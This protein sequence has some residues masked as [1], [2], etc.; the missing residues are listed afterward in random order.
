V[1]FIFLPLISQCTPSVA[2][3]LGQILK[4]TDLEIYNLYQSP[5]D[6]GS[7]K[8]KQYTFRGQFSGHLLLCC[9]RVCINLIM[10]LD[11]DVTGIDDCGSFK[12][13]TLATV[14][15]LSTVCSTFISVM[16]FLL[17]AECLTHYTKSA[18]ISHPFHSLGYPRFTI[19][20]VPM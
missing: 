6:R 13:L 16:T 2:W 3:G 17:T 8:I 1:I 5:W 7:T 19:L 20:G 9:S 14:L 10:W 4:F 15:C 12:V 18:P 11:F